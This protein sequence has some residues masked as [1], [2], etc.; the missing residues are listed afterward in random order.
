M[1]KANPQFSKPMTPYAKN[2]YKRVIK[3][4]QKL[5]NNLKY[6]AE[7]MAK[8]MNLPETDLT[9]SV[10]TA[11]EVYKTNKEIPDLLHKTCRRFRFRFCS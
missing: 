4:H 3:E 2:L 9:E 11:D 8:R 1:G 5:D 6:R 10:A 7:F